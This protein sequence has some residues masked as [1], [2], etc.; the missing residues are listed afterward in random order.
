M[1]QKWSQMVYY[2]P[3]RSKMLPNAS[4]CSKML[5]NAPIINIMNIMIII[6]ITNIMNIMNIMNNMN[7]TAWMAMAGAVSAFVYVFASLNSLKTEQK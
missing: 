2:G 3:K 6:N 5:Q 7:I 4:K 1:L